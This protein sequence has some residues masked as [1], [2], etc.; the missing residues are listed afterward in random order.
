LIRYLSDHVGVENLAKHFLTLLDYEPKEVLSL[1]KTTLQYK[2]KRKRGERLTGELRGKSLALIFEKPST[3]TRASMGVAIYEMGGMPFFYNWSELQ[4]GRGEPIKDTARVLARY[5]DAIAARVKRHA[6][7]EELARYSPVPVINMLSDAFH[8]LQA[9]ADYAT[10]LEVKNRVDVTVA[11]IGDGR[12]NVFNSLAVAGV[13]LGARVI[14]AAPPQYAPTDEFLSR[15]KGAGPG[16]V[17][18]THDP[19]EAVREAD[20]VYTDV[21]VSMGQE[22]EREERL[23]AFLPRYQVN[24]RLLS[25]AEKDYIFMHC[26]PAFRGEEVTEEVLEDAKHSVVFDQAEN[27]LHASKAVLAYLLVR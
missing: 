26:L 19:V 12:D 24:T 14:V 17:E 25:H 23:R 18:V 1:V 22:A 5:H 21:F 4:L 8:P 6:T 27:R 7:L 3:R 11:F 9:I 2:A 20:V 13:K 16:R 10:I 15:L